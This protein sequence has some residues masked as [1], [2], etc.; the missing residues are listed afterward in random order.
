MSVNV[1]PT[2][3]DFGSICVC[4]VRYALGRNTYMPSVVCGFVKPLLD[5]IEPKAI[6]V[7][8]RDVDEAISCPDLSDFDTWYSFKYAL[9]KAKRR[10]SNQ[11]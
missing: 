10:K 2:T 6:S 11:N 9:V 5:R 7:M 4:A 8:L 1:D 3:D